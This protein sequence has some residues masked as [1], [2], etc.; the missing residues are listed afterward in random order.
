M[1]IDASMLG[2]V[3]LARNLEL[4]RLAGTE[5]KITFAGADQLRQ[6]LVRARAVESLASTLASL[7][8]D[9]NP[10]AIE[11]GLVIKW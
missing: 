8:P 9:V 1:S 2:S 11:F 10:A 3:P 5:S 4:G 6:E 7:G